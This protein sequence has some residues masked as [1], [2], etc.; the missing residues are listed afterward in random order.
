M[1]VFYFSTQKY[2]LMN[3][4]LYTK[5]FFN[6]VEYIHQKSILIIFHKS[7]GKGHRWALEA[8]HSLPITERVQLTE[9]MSHFMN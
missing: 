8:D 7:I 9:G 4:F 3:L 5:I 1:F 6:V 2:S